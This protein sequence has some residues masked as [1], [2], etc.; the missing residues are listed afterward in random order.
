MKKILNFIK[1]YKLL[2]LATILFLVGL[3]IVPYSKPYAYSCSMCSV[4][5]IMFFTVKECNK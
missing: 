2:L 1:I 5:I 3:V 4:I